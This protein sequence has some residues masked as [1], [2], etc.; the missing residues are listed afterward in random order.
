MLEADRKGKKPSFNA[1]ENPKVV[2]TIK[3]EVVAQS[4]F[5]L[6]KIDKKINIETLD[7][8]PQYNNFVIELIMDCVIKPDFFQGAIFNVR[9]DYL[10]DEDILAKNLSL[11][12]LCI[13]T[14][15]PIN[16]QI[17]QQLRKNV[18]TVIYD[19][20]ENFSV[21]FVKQML[22]AGIPCQ[23]ITFLEGDALNKA[24]LAFFDYGIVIKRKR[25]TVNDLE[26]SEKCIKYKENL[27]FKTRKFLLSDNK[28]YLHKGDWINK[29]PVNDFSNNTG[30]VPFNDEDFW[31]ESEFYYIFHETK[32]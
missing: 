9:M 8:G 11:R 31:Q 5:D 18:A 23:M 22:A 12:N 26:N 1:N 6:L 16:I 10:F 29:K 20:D 30:A 25:I 32:L 27:K 21:E 28:I 15:K 3:P 19:I 2:N 24:K 4:I 17:L 7:V 13:L 14:N